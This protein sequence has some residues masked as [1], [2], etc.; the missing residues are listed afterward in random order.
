MTEKKHLNYLLDPNREYRSHRRIILMIQVPERGGDLVWTAKSITRFGR[1]QGNASEPGI[2][3]EAIDSGNIS[4]LIGTADLLEFSALR[5]EVAI[6]LATVTQSSHLKIRFSISKDLNREQ[7][8]VPFGFIEQEIGEI[9][10]PIKETVKCET[11]SQFMM[12]MIGVT[13]M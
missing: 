7:K 3:I 10:P 2:T 12:R 11:P 9:Y 6:Q 4:N 8:L 5:G 13:M 1:I